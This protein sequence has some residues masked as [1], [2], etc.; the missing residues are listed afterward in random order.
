[1][2]G[3]LVAIGGHFHDLGRYIEF[4]DLTD[5]RVIWRGEAVRD[6]SGSI[7]SLPIT[8]FFK[9]NGLGP[10]LRADHTYEVRVLY[11]NPTGDTIPFGGMG[12]IG[13]LFVPD[14]GTRWPVVDTT[15]A[16]YRTDLANQLRD[17]N[18]VGEM[19]ML[20][21]GSGALRTGGS[22]GAGSHRHH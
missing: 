22:A 15:D 19:A 11:E 21:A 4:V 12:V 14:K 17:G 3:R 16:A 7:T 8:R 5:D 2:S 20:R 6:S 1:V 18:V 13:G 10:A 9:W